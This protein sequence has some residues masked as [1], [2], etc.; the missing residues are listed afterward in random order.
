MTERRRIT[1]DDIKTFKALLSNWDEDK[2]GKL[3]MSSYID[4]ITTLVNYKYDRSGIN[5][6]HD[7]DLK[8]AFDKAKQRLANERNGTGIG[9]TMSRA[10]LLKAYQRHVPEIE[11]LQSKVDAMSEEV[12]EYLKV[13]GENGVF[14]EKAFAYKKA[15]D[16]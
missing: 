1:K 12:F 2:Q 8:K 15:K 4:K 9:V 6:T 7:G 3:S 16:K 11:L 13:L 10:E 5:K 14:P